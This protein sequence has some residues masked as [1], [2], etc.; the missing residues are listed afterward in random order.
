CHFRRNAPRRA[1]K[2]GIPDFAFQ[3]YDKI[4]LAGKLR[5]NLVD[6]ASQQAAIPYVMEHDS[7]DRDAI[8]AFRDGDT[9]YTRGD[10]LTGVSQNYR[11]TRRGEGQDIARGMQYVDGPGI[12]YGDKPLLILSE[13]LRGAVARWNGF[14][15]LLPSNAGNNN[16]PV[17]LSAESPFVRRVL[18]EQNRYTGAFKK[19]VWLALKHYVQMQ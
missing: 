14:E 9:D 1:Q 2:R 15:W 8:Q 4:S 6:T 3:M 11:R 17:D 13:C 16:L 19:P 5:L 18:A 12:P 7:G 10:P